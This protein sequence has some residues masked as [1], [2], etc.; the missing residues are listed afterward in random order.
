MPMSPRMVDLGQKA[1]TQRFAEAEAVIQGAPEVLD[2]LWAGQLPKGEARSAAQ[3]AGI[4]AAKRTPEL[5]PMCHPIRL[6][7]VEVELSRPPDLSPIHGEPQ[8]G[9]IHIRA[10]AR[11]HDR[12]GVEMEAL[13]AAAIAALTLYDW[14]KSYDP[15]MEITVRLVHKSGGKSGTWTRTEPFDTPSPRQSSSDTP[16]L[17]GVRA[18]VIT[19]SDRASQGLYEDRSGALI[20][21]WLQQQ[22]AEVVASRLLPD[23]KETLVSELQRLVEAHHPDLILTTGGTGLGPRDCVP[24]A[25]RAVIEREAPGITEWLRLRTARRQP[26]AA[27]SRAVAGIRANT[28]I[29]NLPGSPRAVEE[30][31]TELATLLPHAIEMVRGGAH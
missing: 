28:L 1:E 18:A 5:L 26:L 7:S 16:L 24:E 25:T 29:V 30:H 21:D 2:A 4:L 11:T 8:K 9:S 14:A 15:A 12:T 20:R 22:G 27:L 17:T 3:I 23:E 13:M 6:D 19:C 10:R 31:L